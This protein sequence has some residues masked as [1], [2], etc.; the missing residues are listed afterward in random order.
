MDYTNELIYDW[1]SITSKIHT[2]EQMI[3]MLG[4][5]ISSFS[6]TRGA[7]GYKDRLYWQFISVHF[8][9][10]PEQGVWLELSGRGCRAFEEYGT[11]DYEYL[12]QTVIDAGNQMKITRLDIAFDDR[13]G[14][15]DIDALIRDTLSGYYVAK[16]KSWECIQ[17]SKGTSVV[18]GSRQSPVLIRI[19]DK[20][21]E[22]ELLN[23]HWI[24]CELQLRDDRC[25]EF[26]KLSC[27]FGQAFAG[28][29][30]NYLRYVEPDEDDENKWRWPLADYWAEL[31]G[32]AIRQRI[33]KKP[34]CEYTVRRCEEYVYN[35]AGN[36]IDALLQIYDVDVFMA[37]LRERKSKP[38]PKYNAIINE[39]YC[40]ADVILDLAGEDSND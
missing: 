21:A 38:S 15:L 1:V 9:G 31:I 37:K 3:E 13:T 28:V 29:L 11:G 18:I 19:Y 8:N 5:P 23:A 35:Q 27:E 30:V 40:W 7:H 2:P 26:V 24:R 14:I 12:F 17:S 39:N 6:L 20:A 22:Q 16:A 25:M 36:A 34:G 32:D 33:Y 10:S 4:L